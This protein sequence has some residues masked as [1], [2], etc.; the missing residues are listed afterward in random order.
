MYTDKDIILELKEIYEP[1]RKREYLDKRNYLIGVLSHRFNYNQKRIAKYAG[2]D[3]CTVHY[4]K[5]LALKL[6]DLNDHT[7]MYNVSDYIEKFPHDF[8]KYSVGKKTVKAVI[9]LTSSEMRKIKR[10]QEIKEIH[11]ITETYRELL[12]KGLRAWEE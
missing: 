1:T 9:Y 3:R 8:K 4:S 11:N 7:F 6:L 2:I 5:D 12:I 10:Y